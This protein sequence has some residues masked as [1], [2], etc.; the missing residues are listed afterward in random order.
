MAQG[1]DNLPD[2]AFSLP[3]SDDA[4]GRPI[5]CTVAALHVLC[6]VMTGQPGVPAITAPSVRTLPEAYI[7]C[8]K[9]DIICERNTDQQAGVFVALGGQ[10][11]VGPLHTAEAVLGHWF[12]GMGITPPWQDDAGTALHGGANSGHA[13][14]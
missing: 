8:R 7:Q 12:Q 10:R 3:G 4:N 5:F 2:E 1:K 9:G 14:H 6:Y 11:F 13:A